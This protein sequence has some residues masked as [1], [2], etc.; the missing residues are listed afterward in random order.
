MK[1][2]YVIYASHEKSGGGHYYSLMTLANNM[3]DSQDWKILNIGLQH[4]STLVNNIESDFIKINRNSLLNDL[5]QLYLYTKNYNP[6]V[7]HCFDYNSWIVMNLIRKLIYKPLVFT[8][9][10]GNDMIRYI[11]AADHYIFFSKENLAFHQIHSKSKSP[12]SL[13]PNRVEEVLIDNK[14]I[15]KLKKEYNLENK[16]VLLRISRFSELHKLSISQSVEVLKLLRNT[17]QNKE[18][19]LLLI[20]IVQSTEVLK[21]I[22][23]QAKDFPVI[24]IDDPY[25][26][27]NASELIDVA[28]IVI[29]TGRGVMEASSLNKKILCPLKNSKYPAPFNKANFDLLFEKN[30]SGR[31]SG[32]TIGS[33]DILSFINADDANYS[34]NMYEKYFAIKNVLL[35]YK[36]IYED[37][38]STPSRTSIRDFFIFL[39][40]TIYFIFRMPRKG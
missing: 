22:K 29:A 30:F 16:L 14:R 27:H 5:K 20:G 7:I 9:C 6:D 23:L 11:P 1:V 39:A 2:L 3:V 10:G 25:Y 24:I 36:K 19:I 37:V 21:E 15:E 26:T 32:I 35:D 38:V 31:A 34:L 4:V 8:K 12:I 17:Y 18:V 13:I 40:T 28:D 33:K